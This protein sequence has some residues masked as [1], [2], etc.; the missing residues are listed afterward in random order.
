MNEENIKQHE[1]EASSIIEDLTPNETEA[2][3]I[4]GGPCVVADSF[5]FGVERE[6]K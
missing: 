2:E 4:K 6:M 5:S 1:N 3:S